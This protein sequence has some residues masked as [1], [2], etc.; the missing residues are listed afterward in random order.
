MRRSEKFK[1][2]TMTILLMIFLCTN[3]TFAFQA[4]ASGTKLLG[5]EKEHGQPEMIGQEGYETDRFIIKYKESKGNEGE[6]TKKQY[7]ELLKDKLFSVEKINGRKGPNYQRIVLNQ[8]LKT[9]DFLDALA[10][11]DKTIDIE[12]IQPD[13]QLSCFSNDQYYASQWGLENN[14]PES[15]QDEEFLRDEARH[16][17]PPHLRDTMER[18]PELIEIIRNTPPK[19]LRARLMS[20]KV[21][22]DIPPEILFELAHEPLLRERGRNRTVQQEYVCDAAVKGAWEKTNGEGV[23]V[24]VIDT[25]IDVTHED[26]VG[27]IWEN[28]GEIPD[29]GLDDDG[30]GYVDDVYGWN[31]SDGNNLVFNKD[32]LNAE[33]HGTHVAGII[34]AEKDNGKGVAGTAPKAKIM[35]L[36]V[37]KD[38]TAYTSEIIAAIE[39]AEKMGAR[40]V[41]ASWGS[42]MDNPALKEAIENSKMLFV[43]AT[44]NS[45]VNL[46]NSPVYPAS[47]AGKNIISVASL[48]RNG[49]LSAFSNYGASAVDVAAPGEKIISTIPG[50][51]YANMSGT[52]MAAAFVSGEAAL[53][54]GMD[55]NLKAADIKGRI[56]GYCDRLSSLKGKIHQSNKVNCTN[57]VN[58]SGNNKLINVSVAS[59]SNDAVKASVTS[60][61]DSFALFEASS[62]GLLNV[63]NVVGGRYHSLAL[64][65]DGT[66]WA[67]GDNFY[68]QLGDGTFDNKTIPVQVSELTGVKAIAGGGYHSLALKEDGTVWAWGS[69]RKGQLGNGTYEDS[70][71]SVQVSGLSGVKA[72][73]GGV[74][75]SLAL[76]EDGTVWAWGENCD[77]QLGNGTYED[78]AIPVQVSGLSGVKAIDGGVCHSL[79]LKGDGT[80]WAWGANWLGQL[81][82]GTDDE[83]AIP[84]QASGLIGVTAIDSGDYHS[85]ALKE[86]GTVW[87]WGDNWKGQLG[88]GT[89]EESLIPVQVSGLTGVK[90]IATGGHHSL[91]LKESGTVWA[92]GDNEDGQLG[93]GT[94]GTIPIPVQVSGL[95]GG[96]AIAGGG[97]HSLALK[98]DGTVWAWGYNW[99]GELGNGTDEE[100]SIPVQVSG[101]TGVKAIAGGYFHSL[102]LKEDGTVWAW[103][104]NRDGQLGNGTYEDSAIPVQ[105]SGLTGVKAITGGG[106]HSL[107]LKEDGTVWVWGSNRKGQL[108]N[109]TYEE[110]PIAVQVS[111]LTGVKAVAGGC[112]HS[113]ALKEDGTVWAWGYNWGGQLG[114]GTYEESPI[115]VQVSGLTGVKAIAGGGNHS[116]ALKEDG[117]VWAWGYNWEGQLGDDTD[118]NSPIAVQVSGLTGVKAIAGGFEHSLALKEDG[119]VWVWGSNWEGQLGNGTY[120]KSLIPVQVSGLTGVKAIAGGYFH[121]IALKEDGTVWACGSNEDGQLGDGMKILNSSYPL[122]LYGNPPTVEAFLT[123]TALDLSYSAIGGTVY[124]EVEV[125]GSS[126]N[127][128]KNTAYSYQISSPGS[129]PTYRV[130]SIN[131]DGLGLW[132]INAPTQGSFGTITDNSIETIW[133]ANGNPSGT[134]YRIAA[135]D[136][137]DE[138]VKENE[139]TSN[140]SDT[141]T[142]LT[143]N[144][145]YKLK[146]KAKNSDNVETGWV[147]LGLVTTLN[148]QIIN[149]STVYVY[150][151]RN[152]LDYM[153][154]QSG[155]IID[156]QYDNNGN[157]IRTVRSQL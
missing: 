138:L 74:C 147:E 39:Y 114:N 116:L 20:K 125:N 52:S 128:G 53:L 63:K 108:G 82:D 41:N 90:A 141:I 54:L 115:A 25:G 106:N 40:I 70:A 107:A 134:L 119:T 35:P 109:G 112:N 157:L 145:F 5:I 102:A 76:K 80:V 117:T 152:R 61:V 23:L 98:E 131:M 96:K 13:Y 57:A 8:K 2:I 1:K 77:G 81:G 142:N 47:F 136:A 75:H 84:V 38:G 146:G 65:E 104:E 78:S 156:F 121:S 154:L 24:A 149:S 21:M 28:T 43:C 55:K 9:K 48:N 15:A 64:K 50:N 37:F 66:V 17:L 87:V 72:I 103:G 89:Y 32:N 42:T 91:A 155:E 83:S 99:D 6:K 67:W 95:T 51:S 59:H 139:W 144:T 18:H 148:S 22:C 135:F 113:L 7:Q 33:K 30:N 111:G 56:V 105:V 19:E 44:G 62:K 151:E 118:D 68:G 12:Y 58:K 130:R 16:R 86:D 36:K 11:K 140:F 3:S 79:A 93:N 34:A 153:Q 69:N 101:L 100:S 92:W 124:Y 137:N 27:N 129:L 120:E 94:C 73:D 45:G 10:V 29:N 123:D 150:D 88:N 26:L 143:P 85:L 127:N 49:I 60:G 97:S 133:G 132:S 46:E 126:I 14:L 4:S 31:F 110:S 71:I 122:G